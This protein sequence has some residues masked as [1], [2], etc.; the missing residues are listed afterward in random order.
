MNLDL[1]ALSS[2][3]VLLAAALSAPLSGQSDP[4]K[5]A[6]GGPDGPWAPKGQEMLGGP[7]PPGVDREKMWPAPTSEDWKRPCLIHWQRTWDDAV[8]VS[9]ATGKPLMVCVNMD[10]EVASEHYAG[11]RYRDPESAALYEPYVCVIASVYRHSPRDFDEQGRR[12]VCP[13]FGSVTCGEHIAIETVLYQKYFKGQRVAPRHIGVDLASGEPDGREAFDIYYAWDTK[14]IFDNLKSTAEQHPATLADTHGD[15]PILERVASRDARDRV[16]VESAYAQGDRDQKRS[17][18]QQAL[19]HPDAAPVDLLREAIFGF[20]VDL[21]QFARSALEKSQAPEAIPVINEALRVPMAD[22][23][24][25]ALV[26]ALDRL[27]EQT[28]RARTLAVVQRGLATRSEWIDVEAWKKAL[29]APPSPSTAAA[30]SPLLAKQDEI[31]KGSDPKAHLELAEAFLASALDADQERH[32]ARVLLMD[33]QTAALAAEKLGADAPRVQALLAVVAFQQEDLDE[34]RAHAAQALHGLPPAPQGKAAATVLQLFAESRQRAIGKALRERKSWPP[35]W[36]SDVDAAYAVLAVHPFGGDE[37]VVARYDLLRWFGA[38]VPADLAL[39]QG[40]ARFP[41][42][43]ALHD[44]MR[45]RLLAE[46]GAAGLEGGYRRMLEAKEADPSL[47][48]FAGY[49]T[50]VAAEYD[51]RAGTDDDAL[52]RYERAIALYDKAAATFPDDKPTADHYVALALAGRAHI[53]NERAEDEKAVELMVAALTRCPTAAATRDGLGITPVDTARMTIS[54]LKKEKK[55]EL[56]ARLQKALDALDPALLKLPGWE[57][58]G[59]GP[60]NPVKELPP[61][62]A[63]SGGGAP[64]K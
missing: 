60:Q 6:S 16:A 3:L 11:K 29:T 14:T 58:L 9:K 10:G 56:A 28:P 37:H 31:L 64:P 15:R 39:D 62:P 40:L 2:C 54:R 33:A 27:G 35:E 20:D 19:D 63:T 50:M 49:A 23:E 57:N 26:A 44:R 5:P 38:T 46:T 48:W 36:L 21:A 52:A 13:R 45:G 61:P 25:A 34:A 8:A 43:E 55:D 7:P 1:R 4:Y 24:H 53:A 17:L 59:P 47:V 12:V 22:S 41:A 51:C 30:D 42:S 18:I 32:F